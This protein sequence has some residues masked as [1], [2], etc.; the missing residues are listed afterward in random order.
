MRK[1]SK[2]TWSIQ[3]ILINFIQIFTTQTSQF[4]HSKINHLFLSRINKL[5]LIILIVIWLKSASI[6]TKA[7]TGLLLSTYSNSRYIAI[8]DSLEEIYQDQTLEVHSNLVFYGDN[9]E[10]LNMNP[11]IIE[12]IVEREKNFREKYKLDAF[13]TSTTGDIFEKIVTGKLVVICQTPGRIFFE[14]KYKNWKN[15]LSVSKNKYWST[16]N[17][18]VVP[19][20]G[21]LT[22]ITYSM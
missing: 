6:M 21:P 8:A 14:T 7:F 22:P 11:K 15:M 9:L 2:N 1:I 16:I 3:F 18:H 13:S 17:F 10:T 19:K 4:T 12:N 5:N 20:Y